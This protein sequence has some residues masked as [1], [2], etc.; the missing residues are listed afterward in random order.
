MQTLPFYNFLRELLREQKISSKKVSHGV[1]ES[2][3]FKTLVR[4]EIIKKEQA[5]NGGWNYVVKK[6]SELEKYFKTKFPTPLI[7]PEDAASK[8]RETALSIKEQKCER[9]G[10]SKYPDILVVHHRDRNRK[11]GAKENLELLCPNCHE[12]EH[13]LNSDGR[14]T[15]KLIK[16]PA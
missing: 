9:C 16:T 5:A 1:I 7:K 13:F 11:N 3:E 8:Y 2:A 15:N 14:F 6:H 4:S 12:E 10:Y